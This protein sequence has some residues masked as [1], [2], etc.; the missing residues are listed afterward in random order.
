F[1]AEFYSGMTGDENRSRRL[2]DLGTNSPQYW[3]WGGQNNDP[4]LVVLV[5]GRENQLDR[6]LQEIRGPDWEDAFDV[7]KYLSTSNLF[8]MEPFGFKDGISQPTIDWKQERQVKGDQI[9]YGNLVTLGEFLLG[10]PNEY[11]K[12]TDRPLLSPE[13][14]PLSTLPLA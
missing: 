10:Y 3:D 7:L 1:S 4:H 12:Y 11:G 8:G 9:V 2:G 14:D 6:G 5:Y 13:K